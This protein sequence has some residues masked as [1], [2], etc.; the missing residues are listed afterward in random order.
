MPKI[1]LPRGMYLHCDRHDSK[2]KYKDGSYY[3]MDKFDACMCTS[4]TVIQKIRTSKENQS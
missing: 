3:C 4:I 1:K 2:M